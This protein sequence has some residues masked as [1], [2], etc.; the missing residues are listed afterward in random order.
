[1]TI[2]SDS[3]SMVFVVANTIELSRPL[4]GSD[5]V[6]A[7]TRV[8]LSG[9]LAGGPE[10]A[11]FEEEFAGYCGAAHGIAVGNG[12]VALE[13][14][15]RA[16]GI[17]PGDEVVVPS[18]T[19][20]ATANAV[21]M[22]G[23]TPVF[24]DIDPATMCLSPATVEPRLTTATK[25]VIAVHLF[26]H[27]APCDMLDELCKAHGCVLLEDAAQ[28]LGARWHD[29]HVG[30]FGALGTFSFYPTKAVTTGEGGMVI[31]DDDELAQRLRLLRN[32]GAAARHHHTTVGTNQR[33][34]DIAAAMGRVQLTKLE[35]HNRARRALAARYHEVLHPVV[36][37]PT[38]A[39]GALHAY[40]QYTIRVANR[41]RMCAALE[42]AGVGYGLYYP[43]PCH[44]QPSF[45]PQARLAVTEGAARRVLSIP[46]RPD[47]SPAD[48][49]TVVQAVL[50][51]AR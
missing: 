48:C 29:R 32:H 47:L 2:R 12:T 13:L 41:E 46:I 35:A 24:A 8:L 33:M 39:P 7:V 14:G 19:F 42:R 49:D 1:M 20:I 25:A 22:V 9:Q 3:Q 10:V 11:Q 51:G 4:V 30:T 31:T 6:A 37:V 45:A 43:R 50:D 44:L 27:P 36:D 15:L 18:F 21:R 34:S 28:A 16:L 17:G 40:H 5:E 26:G 23:A 38:T